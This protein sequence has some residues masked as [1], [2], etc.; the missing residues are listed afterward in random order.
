MPCCA[1]YGATRLEDGKLAAHAWL[2]YQGEVIVGGETAGS[3][4]VL[5]TW[6][7]GDPQAG[8]GPGYVEKS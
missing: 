5:D 6:K 2:R 1:V 3:F 7:P 4:S 8:E